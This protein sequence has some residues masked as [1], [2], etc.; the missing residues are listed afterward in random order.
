MIDSMNTQPQD[1]YNI[2]NYTDAELLNILDLSNPTDN[3][4]EAKILSLISKYGYFQ[5]E[6]GRKLRQFYEDIYNHFFYDAA[7]ED[8]DADDE[9]DNENEI[10][11]FEN[12]G[13]ATTDNKPSDSQT[14]KTQQN[15]N[16]RAVN[17][18]VA[19][20]YSKDKLNPLLKQT[21]K[22]LIVI[23]SQ[24]RDNRNTSLSTDFTFNLSDNL[25]DVVNLK[26][27]SFQIPYTWY[28][29]NDNFGSNTFKLKAIS[30]GLNDGLN[31]ITVT[32]PVGNYTASTL[33]DAVNGAYTNLKALEQYADISFGITAASYD[34]V[35]CKS[36]L[37][38]DLKNQYNENYYT[39]K[40][41]KWTSP[42]QLDGAR[43]NSIPAFLGFEKQTYNLDIIYSNQ[44]VLP[45]TTNQAAAA[46]DNNLS[47]YF[48]DNS[49]NYFTIVQYVSNTTPDIEY[50]SSGNSIQVLNQFNITLSN[51][52]VG[53]TYTRTQIYN[54]LRT[55]LQTNPYLV[56][57][58]ISRVDVTDIS[59]NGNFYSH[60][61]MK[62][63]LN[64]NKTVN[65]IANQKVAV[66]FPD[67]SIIWTG[68]TSVFV[69]DN[70]INE[71]S[72]VVGEQITLENKYFLKKPP[73]FI[74]RCVKPFYGFYLDRDLSSN[75]YV[76]N[77]TLN[78]YTFNITGLS[79]I[80]CTMTE[81]ITAINNAII[82]AN[83]LSKSK[84]NNYL[85]DF[86][87][88]ETY[89]QIDAS[90][91]KFN[92]NMNLNKIFT[93]DGLQ[94]TNILYKTGT[95][96]IPYDQTT[97]VPNTDLYTVLNL[98]TEYLADADSQQNLVLNLSDKNTFTSTIPY[99]QTGFTFT[100]NRLFT[101]IPKPK[102][103]LGMENF[104]A[105]DIN[106]NDTLTVP[107]TFNNLAE[108]QNY[109][110]SR[111]KIY[112]L[113]DAN[114]NYGG[115]VEQ[116]NMLQ[117]SYIK[118]TLDGNS[119]SIEF[120]I[121]FNSFMT[122]DDYEL[123]FIDQNV[124]NIPVAPFD[125]YG[126][127]IKPAYTAKNIIAQATN[128]DKVSGLIY[129]YGYN[130]V[131]MGVGTTNCQL[132]Y[133]T[134]NTFSDWYT[135]ND[136][137]YVM[138][139][140]STGQCID[141][142]SITLF[143]YYFE[144]LTFTIVGG[145]KEK[146]GNAIVYSFSNGLTQNNNNWIPYTTYT[147][148]TVYCVDTL[149]F[150]G[151]QTFI[152]IVTG[153]DKDTAK[154]TI[155]YS[156]VIST[157]SNN[158]ILRLA[159]SCYNVNFNSSTIPVCYKW[160]SNGRNDNYGNIGSTLVSCGYS[161]NNSIGYSLN[162]GKTWT[163]VGKTILSAGY[164]VAWNG[165]KFIV[166][167]QGTQKFYN[168]AESTDGIT[169]NQVNF[170][171]PI[172]QYVNAISCNGNTWVIGGV[173]SS[174]MAYSLDNG[175]TW[176][177]I[178]D[179]VFSDNVFSIQYFNLNYKDPYKGIYDLDGKYH[180]TNTYLN[181]WIACGKGNNSI[182]YSS[183]GI[184]WD[185]NY[186]YGDWILND[187][188]NS[189][190]YN[191]KVGQRIY[192]ISMVR[193]P[194]DTYVKIYG[195]EEI[196]DATISLDTTNN[197]IYLYPITSSTGGEGLY[198]PDGKNSIT[199]T[200]PPGTYNQRNLLKTINNLCNTTLTANGFNIAAGTIL[201]P[202]NINGQPYIKIRANINKFYTARDYQLIFYDPTASTLVNTASNQMVV[203]TWDSTLGWLLGFRS[204][205]SYI[206]SQFMGSNNIAKLTSDSVV[207]VN[208]YNYFMIVLD[209]YN[210]NHLNDGLITT[211][212][213]E[214][215]AITP[216]YTNNSTNRCDPTSDNSI[217]SIV[218]TLPG[219]TGDNTNVRLNMTKKQLY[220]AQE[221][222]N[223]QNNI[224]PDII[225]SYFYTNSPFAK[226][227][228][229]VLPL[230]I[231]GQQNNTV[232]VDYGGS[233]QNQ[234]RNYFG[235]VNISRMSIKLVND[236]GQVVDLNNSNWSF[237]LI[238][239]QLYQYKKT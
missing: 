56:Y 34:P 163:G 2:K 178:S 203:S 60:Y 78:D 70:H 6:D 109:L 23:D 135:V 79:L 90:S 41:Q 220:A 152:V 87:I 125:I 159:T 116:Y 150:S 225:P 36:T 77:S 43:T 212:K 153:R 92:L 64:R 29:I 156:D 155:F 143:N 128:N 186:I 44:K 170:Y 39:L 231:A 10:E 229:A 81:Y 139:T 72:N 69:F 236:R 24:Y 219:S 95:T 100:V 160:T 233:L 215:N 218:R 210:Q 9:P 110:T 104:P 126:R 205:I 47:V 108:M 54:E 37:I 211:T 173:G 129:G 147:L 19:L 134:P 130:L 192:D 75:I 102:S 30:S 57:S 181:L 221:V 149:Y 26:L 66:I 13:S 217:V 99:S 119:V 224:N 38:F 20:D 33:I 46:I 101:I 189:W 74:L 194:T 145:S 158:I 239:E 63:L 168:L 188:N 106:F 197:Q 21:T 235:P 118:C 214:N 45:L 50:S 103:G 107:Y 123:V 122:E 120:H 228:F 177:G 31:D 51:L 146:G 196:S 165:T 162:G 184:N 84:Y 193:I 191:L 40:F 127:R 200:I 5:N 179:F 105:F 140:T 190:S 201:A 4:L 226:D 154:D 98:F 207:S 42:Y 175:S 176:T 136:L 1:I 97:L 124:A 80:G 227:L 88:S 18:S 12:K 113:Y 91:N 216:S 169:W 213:R 59:F 76:N 14:N 172:D 55:Q 132:Q 209:D 68:S 199:I 15:T 202:V 237:T 204:N 93:Q 131:S 114:T 117:G 206:L 141:I 52:E 94:I 171:C 187:I 232:F 11:G 71:L 73:T 28:V 230:K 27:Y 151:N 48:L 234:E 62:I 86:K 174:T 208:I 61:E 180:P 223:I 157:D 138:N 183:D 182:A 17:Y 16:D 111:L 89:A 58:D 167:G 198:T 67:D 148:S 7:V 3:E 49:N 144:Q 82:S 133:S 25:K 35:S 32:I 166:G 85:G 121:E 22:R 137:K 195:V 142:A 53:Q 222:L 115:T 185:T 83:N 96:T 161:D 65:N 112:Q 238:C 8:E 164:D